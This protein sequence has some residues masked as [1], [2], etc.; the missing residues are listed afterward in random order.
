[1]SLSWS[2]AGEHVPALH[3]RREGI[4]M[5]D[6]KTFG[7]RISDLESN[8]FKDTA[9]AEGRILSQKLQSQRFSLSGSRCCQQR[10]NKKN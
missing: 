1:M 7:Q 5:K 9:G 8:F 10:G 3:R 4:K 2:V 6:I